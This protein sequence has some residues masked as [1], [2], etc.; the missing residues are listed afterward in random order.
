MNILK[1][2]DLSI[3]EEE[4]QLFLHYMMT[5]PEYASIIEEI[6]ANP[7]NP[8]YQFITDGEHEPCCKHGV[9]VSWQDKDFVKDPNKKP[10]GK[11]EI[12]EKW[13][14]Y[15]KYLSNGR[16]SPKDFQAIVH[17]QL[18]NVIKLFMFH[19]HGTMN[20]M[21]GRMKGTAQYSRKMSARSI[22]VAEKIMR[23]KKYIYFLTV[24]YS[25]KQSGENRNEAWSE[26]GKS[27]SKINRFLREEYDALYIRCLESTKNQY[28]H[29]HY[30]FGTNEEIDMGGNKKINQNIGKETQF[31][32]N[33]Q[34]YLP[35]PVFC[36]ERATGKGA[37]FYVS[38]YISKSQ[39]TDLRKMKV[40]ENKKK[41]KDW[42]KEMATICLPIVCN[43][44][45]VDYSRKID[46][47]QDLPFDTLVSLGIEGKTS[48]DARETPCNQFSAKDWVE[49]YQSKFEF[50]SAEISRMKAGFA[51]FHDALTRGTLTT[52]ER[53]YLD[54]LLTNSTKNCV[55]A[56]FAG[57]GKKV[58]ERFGDDD[59]IDK[60]YSE[61]DLA[62]CCDNLQQ[63]GCAGCPLARFSAI[64]QGIKVEPLPKEEER[65][66]KEM[67]KQDWEALDFAGA[68]EKMYDAFF[69]ADWCLYGEKKPPIHYGFENYDQLLYWLEEEYKASMK[70]YEDRRWWLTY[71]WENNP[72][73][74]RKFKDFLTEWFKSVDMYLQSG[75]HGVKKYLEGEDVNGYF[76]KMW[77]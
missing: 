12:K 47:V 2:Q 38:K 65:Y 43:C 26:Y 21:N 27:L 23:K 35:A 73:M 69:K 52:A 44:R 25:P 66:G 75:I 57:S 58:V 70:E 5:R 20:V 76:K 53:S 32:E 8:K 17:R 4:N 16:L 67:K 64:L 10:K 59:I 72:I 34:E 63:V 51:Y 48:S 3:R 40:P 22:G 36:L 60:P 71:H 18:D 29:A 49:W 46:D 42:I 15:R 41:R 13:K 7:C 1:K 6:S 30:V 55:C 74:S 39:N 62:W 50:D 14:D 28:P 56:C 37:A 33:V 45:Q 31:W 11:S 24:T 77:K 9:P 68:F 19:P 61:G 54:M